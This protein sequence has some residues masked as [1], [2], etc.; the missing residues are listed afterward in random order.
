[1]T[2]RYKNNWSFEQVSSIVWR[3]RHHMRWR[4]ST[5]TPHVWRWHSR[6]HWHPH[7]TSAMA[8]AVSRKL[9]CGMFGFCAATTAGL[10][11]GELKML[12]LNSSAMQNQGVVGLQCCILR[13]EGATPPHSSSS[14]SSQS[15]SCLSCPHQRWRLHYLPPTTSVAAKHHCRPST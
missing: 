9:C 15:M 5:K 3:W 12:M 13:G 1:M 11:F 14:S 4:R 7:S 8:L 6:W 10:N 2:S